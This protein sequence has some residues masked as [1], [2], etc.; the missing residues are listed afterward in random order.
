MPKKLSEFF[1]TTKYVHG[2]PM[3]RTSDG[4]LVPW[5]DK[6]IVNQLLR[7]TRLTHEIFG[8]PPISERDA[9]R[10]AREARERVQNMHPKFISGP[11]I[12]E[13]VNNI[14]L[15]WSGSHPEYQIYRNVLTRVGTPVFDAYE[16]DIGRGWEAKENANLQPNPETAHKKKADRLSKEEYLLL[17][18]PHLSTAHIQGDIHIHDLEYF[19]TRPF[20]QD[21]DLRYFL[22]YGLLPDGMGF[23]SSVAGPAKHPEVA[24]LHSVKVLAA[25]QTN[26]SGGQGFMYYTVFLAPYMRGLSYKEV[27]QLAQ[28]MFYELTQ[29]YVTRGG[30][31]VF[32]NIQLPMGVPRIWEDKPVVM[33]GQVGPDVYGDYEDEVRMFFRAI[34]EVALEGD[35]WGKPFNFPKMEEYVSPEFFRPEYEDLW[36][37][38]HRVIAKFGAPYLDN[39]FPS[40]RG[41]G[42]GV[43][44]YQC[45]AYNFVATTETDEDFGDKMYFNDGAH[46]SLGGWQVVS[47]NM[48][49]LAYKADG[50][51]DRLREEAYRCMDLAT[52]AFE[53]K[54]KWMKIMVENARIPFA[55]QRPRDPRTG[56]RA[57]PAVDFNELVYVIGVTGVNEMVQHFTGHQLHGNRDALKVALRLLV[58]ME[59]HRRELVE[60]TGMNIRLA[61]TPAESSAQ[62]LATAD[63]CSP[64][65]REMTKRVVKGDLERAEGLLGKGIRRDVPIYYTNGTHTYVGARLPL[66]RKID[67]EHKFFPILSGGNIFHVWLGETY[68]DAEALYHLTKR[69]VTKTQIGY[70]AYT[71]DMTICALCNRVSFGLLKKC[72]HCG[73][74][75]V[76]WWSRVTGYYQDV[77]GWN[78]GKKAE[79]L[80]RHRI[81]I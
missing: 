58:D 35:Y 57:P 38:V 63:L 39:M 31:L 40:Y 8:I 12:R 71:K 21:W 56:K 25:A 26:F 41:Y 54:H 45:C 49:R 10:I 46:F 74:T 1:P 50:D 69:I 18:D 13:I 55:V 65:F 7:E 30:Q 11:L 3:V 19:G 20:C 75:N 37:L 32:S 42:K 60:R 4:Y 81:V 14:L 67:V 59:K 66:A 51:Y 76:R 9:I 72:P 24:V 52:K 70:F 61:R 17:M 27:K 6:A 16:I 28:M 22:Y 64:D 53:I 48:P 79:L 34:N 33:R 44:C 80:D 62:R 23:K 73:S 78:E 29:T 15:E 36:L 5:T 2:M 43:S 77:T 47:V 68:P